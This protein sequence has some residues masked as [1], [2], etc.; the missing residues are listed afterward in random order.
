MRT[1]SIL[2]CV[3][4]FLCLTPVASSQVVLDKTQTQ[5]IL[6]QLTSQAYTTWVTAGTIE[7]THQEYGAPKTTDQTVIGSEIDNAIQEY[8]SNPNKRELTPETQQMAL[9]AIPFNVR[10]KLANEYSM[11]SLHTVKYDG[12]RFYWEIYVSSRSDSIQPDAS[13]AENTMT[14]EF[15]MDWNQRRIFAWDGQK[16]TAYAVSGGQAVVDTAGRL[17]TPVVTGPLTAGLIP[18][19]SGRYAYDSL[20]AA[21]VS[22]SR[23]TEDSSLVQM[24]INHTDGFTSEFTLDSAKAYAVTNATLTNPDGTAVLYTLSGYNS[25]GGRWVPSSIAIER[26]NVSMNSRAPTSELW[27]LTTVSTATPPS[28]SFSVSVAIDDTIQY[29]APGI[30]SSI[31]YTN[32]YETDTDELLMERLAYS[33]SEGIGRQNCATAALQHVAAAFQKPV[34]LVAMA[35]LV[36]SNGSTNLYD[37]KQFA[38]GLGLYSRVVKTD[39]AGLA[40]LGTAK[41][42]VH[43]PGKNHF[44]VVDR[45]DGPYIWLIDLSRRNFYYRQNVHF[46]PLEWTEGTAL[47]LSEQPIPGRFAGIPDTAAQRFT[48]GA[49]ACNV[50][51]QEYGEIPCVFS[52]GL[53][54]GY[55]VV[56]LEIWRCGPAQTGTCSY[57]AAIAR[58]ESLCVPDSIWGCI[59]NGEWEFVN[60]RACN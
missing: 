42:I 59:C 27:T 52:G 15:D 46:F 51:V 33:V 5:E 38:Q 45:V 26:R 29:T 44:A 8:V 7:A 43:I 22:A 41:A 13:L 54:E 24:R 48:G 16:Y 21:S 11:A 32:S 23:T 14:R 57:Y 3:A 37:L 50:L 10:Y 36:S 35:G 55:Y 47:L 40:S 2:C 17:G 58:L 56:F 1:A 4:T 6:K 31:V 30:R 9:D 49:Y 34:S 39:L 60:T 18:W 25:I 53:C 12:N 28:S 19:G 20:A